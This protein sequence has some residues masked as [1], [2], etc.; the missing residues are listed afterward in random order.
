VYGGF[1][2]TVVYQ[3]PDSRCQ[4]FMLSCIHATYTF[5]EAPLHNKL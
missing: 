5:T 3:A 2:Q 1:I 4:C